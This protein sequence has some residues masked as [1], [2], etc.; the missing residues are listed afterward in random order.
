MSFTD[1][2]SVSGLRSQVSGLRSQVSGRLGLLVFS[3]WSDLTDQRRETRDPRL[4]T[5]WLVSPAFSASTSIPCGPTS[6]FRRS[7]VPVS[8]GNVP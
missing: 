3:L 2:P 7:G 5:Y 1:S 4:E 8:T 6:S